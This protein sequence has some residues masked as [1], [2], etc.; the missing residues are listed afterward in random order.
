M[1]KIGKY[2]IWLAPFLI[3]AGLTV[4]FISEDWD[5]IPLVLIIL[6]LVIAVVWLLWQ[7]YSTKWWSRRSTQVG[8]N[9][10]IATVAVVA[11]L[12]LI[13]FLATRYNVRTDL[14]ETNLFTLAPQSVEVVKNL[15]QPVKLWI[16]DANKN[17]LDEQ[18]LRNYQ[19]QGKNFTFEY[20]DPNARPNLAQ[21]FGVQNFGDIYLE[22]GE[23]QQLLQ[24][25]NQQERLSESILTNGLLKI[26]NPK[27]YK[28]Y[29]LQ[30]HGERQLGQGRGKISQAVQALGNKNYVGEP[31]NLTQSPQIPDDAEVVVLAGPQQTI[32]DSEIQILGDYA[33]AGGNLLVMVDP[34]VDPK[35]DTF[36]QEWGV[37]LDNRL[38]INASQPER[39]AIS[40]VT[41]YGKHPITE[42]FNN[43]MS[44]YQLARPIETTAVT[45]VETVPLLLTQAY[46]ATWAESDWESEELEYNE[47]GDRQ[48]P[49][50]LGVALTRKF[51]AKPSVQP[52][53]TPTASPTP[54]PTPTATATPTPTPSPTP[55]AEN[56][57]TESRMV[58]FGDSD[59]ITDGWFEELNRDVF[60]NSITWLRKPDNPSLSISP[61]TTKNRRLN[62]SQGQANIIALSSVLVLPILAFIAAGLLWF[63]RR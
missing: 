4:G 54:T 18:L 13:N 19:Q 36:L 20:V 29:F 44:I 50:I 17:P 45:D 60:L 5:I 10:I 49:L 46:P 11:I 43:S 56:K 27:I 23:N 8:T 42:D 15:E 14:T 6:G 39:K 62:F 41:E 38:A 37:T 22:S 34:G 40:V 32:L 33:A 16:F 53:P 51:A 1:K 61:K 25:L 58:V 12:G 35:L 47:N 9:A 7:S 55:T 31:L 21:K 57:T 30:G 24:S 63:Q 48:G 28:V 26:T 59:F 2:V 3:T 52:T